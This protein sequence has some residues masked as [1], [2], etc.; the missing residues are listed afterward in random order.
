MVRHGA[1]ARAITSAAVSPV[2]VPADAGVDIVSPSALR[3]RSMV[4]PALA[5]QFGATEA[6]MRFI[7][8]IGRRSCCKAVAVI[9]GSERCP[10]QAVERLDARATKPT[11]C[12]ERRDDL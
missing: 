2:A 9:V 12:T 7:D 5:R 8:A 6:S 1:A 11:A 10:V 4:E 3:A